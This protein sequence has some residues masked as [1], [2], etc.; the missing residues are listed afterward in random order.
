M[1]ATGT[2]FAVA[3]AV[4]LAA[5][6][7]LRWLLDPQPHAAQLYIAWVAIGCASLAT[8]VVLATGHSIHGRVNAAAAVGAALLVLLASW[9]LWFSAYLMACNDWGNP[10]FNVGC[11]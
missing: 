4:E 5:L 2:G 3:L 8:A 9:V 7:L 10:F 11:D 1:S 6:A